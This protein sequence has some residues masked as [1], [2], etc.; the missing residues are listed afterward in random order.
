MGKLLKGRFAVSSIVAVLIAILLIS[1]FTAA[2]LYIS[3]TQMQ[4]AKTG[5][6]TTG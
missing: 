1:V 6:E 2:L 3:T 5:T 4:S